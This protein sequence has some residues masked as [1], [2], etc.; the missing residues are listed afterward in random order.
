MHCVNGES[1]NLIL[2]DSM[3]E[4]EIHSSFSLIDSD[5]SVAFVSNIV[6]TIEGRYL[7]ST[8][9]LSGK[10]SDL[11]NFDVMH[12]SAHHYVGLVAQ[13][14]DYRNQLAQQI[15]E[16]SRN[17]VNLQYDTL[18]E[19]AGVSAVNTSVGFQDPHRSNVIDHSSAYQINVRVP[20]FHLLYS[21]MQSR[22][23]QDELFAFIA[24]TAVRKAL[25]ALDRTLGC[26]EHFLGVVRK[27]TFSSVR[28][29]CCVCW[30]KRRWFL[31]HGARPPKL[32]VHSILNPFSE[33][34]SG[35]LHA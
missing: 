33:A 20:S 9:P 4:A 26:V 25:T 13:A 8:R 29:F 32:T 18:A 6:Q 2:P 31:F 30:E 12:D 23:V 34:C 28:F 16:L 27:A 19:W 5:K 14:E 22:S 1:T 17:L 11:V 35:A 15:R 3:K 24:E 10:P 21:G 7:G